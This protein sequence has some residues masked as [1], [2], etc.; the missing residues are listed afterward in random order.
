MI[1]LKDY[2]DPSLIFFLDKDN[3]NDVMEEMA[4]KLAQS[5]KILDNK[6]FQK[7]LFEREKLMSTGIGL[8]IAIPHVKHKSVADI[9]IGIGISKKGIEWESIDNKP[10][11]LVFMIAGAENQHK[12]YLQILSKIILA[13]KKKDRREKLLNAKTPGDVIVNFKSL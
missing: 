11:R 5:P 2:I 10:V 3:K 7:A 1:Y 8:G 9:V 12:V 13:L 4:G 6:E